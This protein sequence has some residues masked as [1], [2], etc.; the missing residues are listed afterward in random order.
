MEKYIQISEEQ[1]FKM[2]AS[3]KNAILWKLFQ[4]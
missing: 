2:L 1:Y 4:S 3:Y